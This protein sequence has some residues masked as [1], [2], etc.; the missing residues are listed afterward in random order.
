MAMLRQFKRAL[1]SGPAVGI[2]LV[3]LLLLHRSAL[4]EI[5]VQA[6]G[7]VM[8][9]GRW[10]RTVAKDG[11]NWPFAQIAD[12][13]RK[14]DLTLAN[15]E[16]PLTKRGGEFKAKK[17]RFRV[18]PEAALALKKNGIT[19]VNLAN[20]H[21]MD[22]GTVGL[23]D[24]LEA[25]HQAGVDWVG[26]GENLAAARRMIL[27]QI[28]GK[29]VAVLAYSLTLPAEFWANDLHSGTMPLQERL[30]LEDVAV[31]RRT[32]DIVIVSVHWGEE[33]T[34]RLRPY[35]PRLGHMMI[36]AGV[37]VVIGHHPHVLQ[38]VERYKNGIIF[39][40]LGNF[41][42]AARG[43]TADRTLLVRLHFNGAK[44]T[45]EL[46]PVNIRYREVGFQPTVLAGVAADQLIERLQHL[47]PAALDIRKEA[48]RYLIDF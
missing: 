3:F 47:P 31:A 40:S 33:G 42:F 29:K 19:T 14:G 20:N 22:F 39:Y 7:D 28:Q 35:Q 32:A 18:A 12:E 6:V 27:Y 1:A 4:A 17:F 43:R 21:S 34:A 45:A 15:L 30:M 38:G 41:A 36:D 16:A 10:E 26:A 13:L 11:Y 44:R 48:G 2:S 46:V 5:V 24:T 23:N 8:L 9:G 25:L 37:D